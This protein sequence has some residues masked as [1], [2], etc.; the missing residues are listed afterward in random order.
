MPTGKIQCAAGGGFS[1]PA[2]KES[3]LMHKYKI[4]VY[5][6]CKNEEQFVDRWLK[7]M[8]EADAVYVA[9]T[10]STDNT[11]KKL[12]EGGAVVNQIFVDPWRF[13]DARNISLSFVPSDVDICVCTDLDEVFEEDWRELL[14]NAWSEKATRLKYMYTWSFNPDGTPGVTF[15]YEKIHSRKGFRWVHPVHEVT[16]YSG[17][18][19]DFCVWDGRIKLYHYPDPTKSRSQYLPLLEQSVAEAPNDDRNMHY[20]GREYMYRQRWDDCIKT[21]EKHLEMPQ[22]VWKDERAASMRY[23]ARSHKALGNFREAESWLY[24]AIAEAPHL[25]EGYVEAAMLFYE[26]G[27]SAG[28]YHMVEEAL[29]ITE[30]PKTYINEA[31]SWDYTIYDL[32]ALSCFELGLYERALELA[33]AA[34]KLSPNDERLR[35][36]ADIIQ[37]ANDARKQN[38]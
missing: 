33:E 7:S 28:V 9:D 2:K 37:N 20:L 32:G 38:L 19:P 14:E 11:A 26:R 23:I 25:R 27:N 4:A 29:K 24:R 35:K 12:R 21:L 5:A 17:E 30:R 13:D 36:N 34:L 8:G 22:A 15:W 18:K 3:Q 10:G 6:I 1:P 16:E 31:F